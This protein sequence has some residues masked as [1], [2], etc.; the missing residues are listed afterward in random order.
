M[1]VIPPTTKT[2]TTSAPPTDDSNPQQTQGL[3]LSR[4]KALGA[5]G[6]VSSALLFGC[7]AESTTTEETTDDSDTS[8]DTGSDDTTSS[9][10]DGT[11]TLI[12]QETQG[13]YPLLAI[14][15]NSAMVRS[16]I[17]EGK[18]GVPLTLTLKLVNVN[19]SCAPITSAS[20]Y[21]WHCDKDGLYSGYNQPAGNT[22]GETY[23]RGIQDV[24]S[25]GEVTFT[26]IYP[27]WY[28]G[29]ITHIHFQVYL[30]SESVATA[31]SQLAFPQAIT[32]TVYASALYVG[33]G[34]NT[35]VTSFSSDNI[36]SD[37]TTYQM[38]SVSGNVSS[39]YVA[40]L[41]VGISA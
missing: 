36:F 4:R 25:N 12:P 14:L 9:T 26:T 13:P 24:D 35:S 22:V 31:T 2:I 3:H 40:T 34:Q 23:C 28:S 16:D 15:S 20:V 41:E 17:T 5:L 7:G 30:Y 32:Q 33:R 6:I 38:A 29:R 21:I 27:G 37:G 10:G 39:G 11:C 18:S 19:D 8:T 1:N